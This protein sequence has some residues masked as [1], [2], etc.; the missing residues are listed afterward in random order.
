VQQLVLL[1]QTRFDML[2]WHGPVRTHLEQGYTNWRIVLL[3]SISL[4]GAAALLTVGMVRLGPQARAVQR[5]RFS[6]STLRAGGALLGLLFVAAQLALLVQAPA[7]MAGY[8][9]VDPAELRQVAQ[10][11]NRDRDEPHVIVTVSNEFHLNILLNEFKGRFVHHWLSPVQTSGFDELLR[12]PFPARSLRLIVDRVHMQRDH[13]SHDVEFWL[14]V[15]LHR[16]FVDWIGSGYEVYS[17]LYPP[18]DISLS[19]VDYRWAAGMTMSAYGMAPVVVD[20][21]EPIWL[22]FHYSAAHQPEVD[23]DVLLQL[24]SPEGSF[25]NGTDGPPQFGATLTSR[26]LPGKTIVDR[27]AVYVPVDAQPGRYDVI[28]GFYGGGERQP[29]FHGDGRLLGTHVDLGHVR[30]R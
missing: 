28:T 19:Q 30:V 9:G 4:L 18:D 24:L 21:G 6:M 10:V 16:Y 17:Y 3:P 13:S 23:Y 15:N 5:R 11:I 2:W 26:W 20:P 27:R 22:E 29:V 25:V 12:P 1:S 8:P 14:N 7:A